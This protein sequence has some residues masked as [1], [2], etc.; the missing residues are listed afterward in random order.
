[1]FFKSN[2]VNLFL[3]TFRF[4]NY[5]SLIKILFSLF[6]ILKILV[7][8]K[9]VT[10]LVVNIISNR[11]TYRGPGLALKNTQI[12][13]KKTVIVSLSFVLLFLMFLINKASI[14]ITKVL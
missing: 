5:F 11:V 8:P 10:F 12:T 7:I 4:F 9:I 2:S 13:A 3:K 1:M 14:V 6:I